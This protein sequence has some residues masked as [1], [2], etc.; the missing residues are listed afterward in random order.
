[1]VIK[2]YAVVRSFGCVLNVAKMRYA[3]FSD[4]EYEEVTLLLKPY[5]SC[6]DSEAQEKLEAAGICVYGGDLINNIIDWLSRETDE[7]VR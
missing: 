2:Q 7:C 6:S 1:M 3:V 5:R 4:A